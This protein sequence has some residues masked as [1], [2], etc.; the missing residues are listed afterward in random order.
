MSDLYIKLPLVVRVQ[1]PDQIGGVFLVGSAVECRSRAIAIQLLYAL[2][3]RYVQGGQHGSCV[4]VVCAQEGPF[5]GFVLEI[6]YPVIE[7]LQNSANFASVD[8][9]G[10]IKRYFEEVVPIVEMSEIEI[11]IFGEVV[12][13]HGPS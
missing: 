13:W 6:R 11:V 5:Q 2:G 4:S 3:R 12:L 10:H 7:I 1:L 9:V 8:G